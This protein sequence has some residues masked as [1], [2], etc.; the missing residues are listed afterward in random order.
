MRI[1]LTRD[2]SASCISPILQR[3]ITWRLKLSKDQ[4]GS[5]LMLVMPSIMIALHMY[6]W[7]WNVETTNVPNTTHLFFMTCH[8]TIRWSPTEFEK[9]A[10]LTQRYHQQNLEHPSDRQNMGECYN[11]AAHP[12]RRGFLTESSYFYRYFSFIPPQTLS[13]GCPTCPLS[14]EEKVRTR[15]TS[16]FHQARP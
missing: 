5:I 8:T 13:N 4:V 3:I 6:Y 15:S 12:R 9:F 2:V 16:S 14:Q 1:A 10:N 7:C 11:R